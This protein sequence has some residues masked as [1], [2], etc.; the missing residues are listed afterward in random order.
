MPASM[1]TEVVEEEAANGNRRHLLIGIAAIL[2]ILGSFQFAR[3]A[4]K[5]EPRAG[6]TIEHTAQIERPATEDNRTALLLE[7]VPALPAGTFTAT[8]TTGA[9]GL[10]RTNSTTVTEATTPSSPVVTGSIGTQAAAVTPDLPL[11]ENIG[12]PRLISAVNAGDLNAI[13]EVGVRLFNG[14]HVTRDLT[15]AAEWFRQAAE[16]GHAA[17]QYR[18]ANALDKGHGVAANQKEAEVWYRR[19]AE[20]GHIK[21]MHNLA[22]LHA[23]G[24]LGESNY[25]EAAH[26]FRMAADRGVRD[27]QYNLA[28]MLARGLGVEQNLEDAFKWFAIAAAAGDQDAATKRDQ[29]AAKLD[30]DALV[31]A[32]LEARIW[33]A[34]PTD[35]TANGEGAS[36]SDW[37]SSDQVSAQV[38]VQ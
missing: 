22:V 24:G 2:L 10:E 37:D 5:S 30:P 27:S 4:I 12:G 6:E 28:V 35:S 25:K 1:Q 19:A 7:T 14:E 15:A 36:A 17:A 32:R 29:V 38:T 26:W 33:Q 23:E 34:V 3:M 21:A 11:P 13:Y 18:Y 16:A 8:S 31:A 9:T 20:Q